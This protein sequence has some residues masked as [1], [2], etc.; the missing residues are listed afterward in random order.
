MK[1][2]KKLLAVFA[3]AAAVGAP[4]VA[5]AQPAPPPPPPPL[6]NVNAF[7]P[8][9][10]QDFAAMDGNWYAFGAPGGLTCVIQRSGMYGCE[11]A[12][13][14]APNGANLVSGSIGGQPGFSTTGGSV[15]APAGEV[16][17]LSPN[18]RLSY[19]TLSC[20]TDGTFT[21]CV[22]SNTGAGFVVDPV[23][24]FTVGPTNPLL[25]RPEPRNPYAN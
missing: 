16:E 17:P 1:V 21:S 19:Q 22:D 2:L 24:S 3:G 14:G 4:G 23:S 12:I 15:F 10:P 5:A 13:P 11:G 6:P 18:T 9:N 20:G 25:N 8:A 7:T